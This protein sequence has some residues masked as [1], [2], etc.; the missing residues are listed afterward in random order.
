MGFLPRVIG[1]MKRYLGFNPDPE[2]LQ[3]WAD[4]YGL[5]PTRVMAFTDGTKLQEQAGTRCQ[6]LGPRLVRLRDER[7]QD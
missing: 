2:S 4:R 5:N 7:D 1:N 3:G 6:W